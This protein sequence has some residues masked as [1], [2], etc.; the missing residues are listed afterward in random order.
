MT[1][2]YARFFA[3]LCVKQRVEA[4]LCFDSGGHMGI[5]GGLKDSRH[6]ALNN[7]VIGVVRINFP[8]GI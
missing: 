1:L 6:R 7:S 2:A 5:I 3:S 8:S 4:A